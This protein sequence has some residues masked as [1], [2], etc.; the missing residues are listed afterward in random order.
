MKRNSTIDDVAKAAGVARVT[1]SRVLN[2][3]ENVRPETRKRVQQAVESLGYSVNQ[4]ARALASGSSRQ[5]MLIHAHSPEREPN[6]YYNAGLELGALRGCSSI[7]LDLVTRAVDPHDENRLR[8]LASILERER[9]AGL[10]L[11][12]PLSDDLEFI[13]TARRSGVR[14]IAVSAGEESRATVMAVGID[15]RAGGLAIGR[16][17]TSLGHRRI[18][19]I[20]GPPEHRA[21]ALRHDGFLEALHEVGIEKEQWTSLGDFTFKS[22]VESADE[23]LRDGAKLTAI[24]CANDDMAAGVMLALHR[25]GLEIPRAISVTGFDDTPMS[26]IVWPPLTTVRQPIKDFAER[27]VHL[28]VD[29]QVN[30]SVHYEALPFALIV[31]E[32]TA[33]PREA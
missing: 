32:S 13:E 29:N 33:P 26:E 5:I 9:P 2:N 20:K 12:P 25:A 22:G 21:A 3:G 30:G 11:S 24:A 15:E 6:S 4:Q 7:G 23:L 18:G 8:L 10:I 14:V 28:L 1:V 16:H 27:A 19:F 31:R 17:L